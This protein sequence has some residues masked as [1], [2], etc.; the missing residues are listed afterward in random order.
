MV[1]LLQALPD[2]TVVVD[3][4][5]DGERDG[6]IGVGEGL[7]AALCLSVRKLPLEPG[8]G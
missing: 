4:A 3:L 7:G 1:G 2:E 6:V 8:H 5:V